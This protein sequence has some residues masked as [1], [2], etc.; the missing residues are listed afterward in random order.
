[1]ATS[2]MR[3]W[4]NE[5]ADSD[6]AHAL[7]GD[8]APWVVWLPEMLRA[9]TGNGRS[10]LI[11]RPTADRPGEFWLDTN[12]FGPVLPLLHFRLGWPRVDVGL[13]RWVAAGRSDLGDPTLSCLSKHW[14]MSAPGRPK[15]GGDHQHDGLS[16]VPDHPLV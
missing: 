12:L 8:D 13:D 14:G 10:D 2:D 4:D 5:T 11:P 15:G 16:K 6:L 1:M 3:P 9:I 7:L